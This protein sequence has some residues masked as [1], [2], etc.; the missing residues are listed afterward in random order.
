MRNIELPFYEI[1]A[2]IEVPFYGG[3]KPT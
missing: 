3:Q 1:E 2:K